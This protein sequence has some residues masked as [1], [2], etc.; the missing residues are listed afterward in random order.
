MVGGAGQGGGDQSN[1]AYRFD[2]ASQRW[3]ARPEL[4]S[5]YGSQAAM[6]FGHAFI[7]DEEGSLQQ[8]DPHTRRVRRFFTPIPAGRDHAQVIA[9][10]DEIWIIAGRF[11]ETPSVA[12]YDPVSETWRNGPRIARARGGFAAAS[13]GDRIV[14][15]G[16]EV[17]GSGPFTEKSVEI[18]HAGALNWDEGPDLPI[19]IHGVT[20][21]AVDKRVYFVSGSTIAGSPN[22][23]TGRVFELVLP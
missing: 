18:Y 6:L 20:G 1:A 11:P 13:V 10:L 7:S 22:G 23:A 8:Y 17:F 21:A 15:G 3:E 12:I 2:V 9:F 16:G 5:T 14:I 4:F 19:G